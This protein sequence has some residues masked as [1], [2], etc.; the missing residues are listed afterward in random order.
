PTPVARSAT[1]TVSGG[2]GYLRPGP[3][4]AGRGRPAHSVA[5]EDPNRATCSDEL[6]SVHAPPPLAR[7][8]PAA[9]P[10]GHHPPNGTIEMYSQRPTLT[11]R[12][13]AVSSIPPSRVLSF[14][15]GWARPK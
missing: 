9:R 7:R 14:G 10:A 11:T 4:G 15:L 12:S 8:I 3:G 2:P 13:R 1:W 6:R 5:G